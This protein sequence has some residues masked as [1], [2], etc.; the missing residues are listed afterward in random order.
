MFAP[1]KW[2]TG[3][4]G[5]QWIV[6]GVL[7]G[8]ATKMLS[9]TGWNISMLC[10]H[11]MGAPCAFLGSLMMDVILLGMPCYKAACSCA[12]SQR[13]S[14]PFLTEVEGGLSLETLGSD[15]TVVAVSD[16]D[17]K[18]GLDPMVQLGNHFPMM[19][20]MG[21]P[22]VDRSLWSWDLFLFLLGHFFS[23]TESLPCHNQL[24]MNI[25]HLSQT[26]ASPQVLSRALHVVVFC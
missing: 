9:R 17:G 11:P 20:V 15:G 23:C 10:M 21:V 19:I 26:L 22:F 18:L 6:N 14:P 7:Q 25:R 16:A 1:R 5:L 24:R 8:S 13:D 12:D 2:S 4:V 3:K